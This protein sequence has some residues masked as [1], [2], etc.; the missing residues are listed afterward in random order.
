MYPTI[1]LAAAHI[2]DLLAEAAAHRLARSARTTS[3]RSNRIAAAARTAW[4]L[5][6]GS[7]EPT[8]ELPRLTDYPY[9]G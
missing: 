5:L 7:G 4:S 3:R 2:D 1:H 9:R 6:A 8:L